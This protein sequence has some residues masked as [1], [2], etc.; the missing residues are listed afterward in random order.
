MSASFWGGGER[1]GCAKATWYHVVGQF[2][3]V[4]YCFCVC[5]CVFFF[6]FLRREWLFIYLFICLFRAIPEAHGSSQLGLES[7]LQLLAHTTATATLDP[8]HVCDSHH[9]SRQRR[10]LNPLNEAG[11]RTRVL[12]GTSWVCYR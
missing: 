5:V 7:E 8:S 2:Y 4:C 6:F 3:A 9:S 10:S 11:D 1:L 12:M